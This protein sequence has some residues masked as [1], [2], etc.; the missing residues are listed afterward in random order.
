MKNGKSALEAMLAQY[1][2]NNKPKY[3]KN[4]KFFCFLIKTHILRFDLPDGVRFND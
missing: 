2:T 4:R 3:E 1:R